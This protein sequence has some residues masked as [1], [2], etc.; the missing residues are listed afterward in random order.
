MSVHKILQ[1]Q[2][3]IIS[4]I[5]FQRLKF[6]NSAMI[7]CIP[8]A[9]SHSHR[10]SVKLDK[11]DQNMFI[12]QITNDTRL[13]THPTINQIQ[14]KFQKTLHHF[15]SESNK[16]EWKFS[17]V[18]SSLSTAEMSQNVDLV[19]LY[20]ANTILSST[21]IPIIADHNIITWDCR[22]DD[23]IVA[24]INMSHH[25]INNSAGIRYTYANIYQYVLNDWSIFLHP[26]EIDSAML[27]LF[28]ISVSFMVLTIAICIGI[29]KS[30]KTMI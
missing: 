17:F 6:V 9:S 16:E 28:P 25:T 13:I 1:N 4:D 23:S 26:Y 18:N 27:I 12:N 30:K 19:H 2:V 3:D 14:N 29:M 10:F 21:D 24:I 20:I 15:V 22:D 5:K 11:S 7:S 8:V